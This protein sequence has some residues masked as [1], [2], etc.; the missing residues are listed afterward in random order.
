[1]DI[2]GTPP[3]GLAVEIVPDVYPVNWVT[4][5]VASETERLCE[6]FER[7]EKVNRPFL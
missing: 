4:G 5:E 2:D 3:L 6:S 7:G 1:M